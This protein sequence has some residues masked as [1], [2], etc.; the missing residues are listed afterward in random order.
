[1]FFIVAFISKN[2]NN[3]RQITSELSCYLLIHIHILYISCFIMV[4]E[5]WFAICRPLVH[6]R[7]VTSSRVTVICL[8]VW[9]ASAVYSIPHYLVT[10]TGPIRIVV[11]AGSS[12]MTLGMVVML[13]LSYSKARHLVRTTPAGTPVACPMRKELKLLYM[14]FIM[15]FGLIVYKALFFSTIIA[16]YGKFG[17]KTKSNANDALG[18]WMSVCAVGNPLMTL[19]IKKDYQEVIRLLLAKYCCIGSIA[20]CCCGKNEL[21]QGK[22][23]GFTSRSS[24]V[25]AVT[26]AQEIIN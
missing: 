11:M 22:L 19:V 15:N 14:F 21:K 17:W 5:R 18:L 16:H 20:R 4:T 3:H 25:T 13:V 7:L 24:R 8:L 1:M 9:P 10:E 12:L 6:N 26:E 23:Y 2:V